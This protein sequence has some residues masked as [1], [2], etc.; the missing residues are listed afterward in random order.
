MRFNTTFLDIV[1]IDLET[2]QVPA[3]IGEP[4]IGK[5]AFVTSLAKSMDT[6]AFVLAC[7]QL[8]DKADLTGARLVPTKDQQS[9]QQEFYPHAVVQSAIEYA[10]NNPREWPILFFDEINRTTSDVTSAVLTMITLR[11]LGREDLPKNLRIMVAG[12]DRGNVTSLDE[13]SLSRFSL[14]R[15]E[16]DAETLINILGDKLNQYVK[17]VLLQHPDFIFQKSVSSVLATDGSNDDDDD[18]ITI[19]SL[20]D[21]GEE[22]NQLTTPRTIE[23]VSKLLNVATTEQLHEWVGTPVML[24]G[25]NITLLHEILESH[26]GNTDFTAALVDKII[27]ALASGVEN[28]SNLGSAPAKPQCYALLKEATSVDQLAHTVSSLTEHEKSGCL[29]YALYENQD[30]RVIIEQLLLNTEVLETE[31]NRILIQLASQDLLDDNNVDI[32][33]NSSAPLAK[34]VYAVLSMFR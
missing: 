10:R 6:K 27:N 18:N 2:G 3:L 13:A 26:V 17:E 29:L 25:R 23:A 31:H 32:V 28:S 11:Q 8:A 4:G 16:P 30:N 33:M 9:Y 15:V 20:M 12:N 21:S 1:K 19:S 34:N 22:M 24:P 7:N 14:Y 5:S